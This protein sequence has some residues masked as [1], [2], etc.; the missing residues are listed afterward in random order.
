MFQEKY[1]VISLSF[2]AQESFPPRIKPVREIIAWIRLYCT[3]RWS[4]CKMPKSGYT[5][6]R[7]LNLFYGA[8]KD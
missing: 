1:E 6:I 3:T 2:T 7:L 8:K 4:E 5:I